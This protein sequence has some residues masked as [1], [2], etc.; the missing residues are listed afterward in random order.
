MTIRRLM[1]SA[2]VLGASLLCAH[3]ASPY[4][5]TFQGTFR[6]YFEQSTY[7]GSSRFTV[8]NARVA[9]S[10]APV[11]FLQYKV[12]VDL[13]DRGK[14]KVNDVYVSVL[15]VSSLKLTLGLQ[16]VPFSIGASRSTHLRHFLHRSFVGKH[17]ANL[18]SVGF[19]A[20]YTFKTLS[21]TLEGGI[22]NGGGNEEQGNWHKGDWVYSVKATYASPTGLWPAMAFM[23]RVLENKRVNMGGASL[24]FDKGRWFAEAEG[25]YA[26]WNKRDC[27]QYVA[28]AQYRIP[29]KTR[30]ANLLS[31]EGRFDGMTDGPNGLTAT[32]RVTAGT[33]V[34]YAVAKFH[35][36]LKINYEQYFPTA[37]SKLTAGIIL[38]F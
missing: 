8:R 21:T 36:D 5:P 6:G 9:A 26:R 30:M 37:G 24:T 2:V 31:F 20:A 27:W 23:S 12:Q 14:F 25:F 3:G 15:P 7:D 18:R 35:A 1:S 38:H 17:T 32:K 10:G 33:T 22:F 28:A 19:K 29:L 13:C 34:S 11:D 16:R 4:I